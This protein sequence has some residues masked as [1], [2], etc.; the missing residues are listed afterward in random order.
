MNNEEIPLGGS[1][2][3]PTHNQND[4][5]KTSP[6]RK[7]DWKGFFSGLVFFFFMRLDSLFFS[8]PIWILLILHFTIKLPLKWFFLAV[9]IFFL[10]GF[11]RYLVLLFARWG[12]SY[13]DAPKENKNPYSNGRGKK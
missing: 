2:E 3:N 4:P 10:V 12:A 8:L 5:R 7:V 11:F 13:E 1:M 9:G 6:P